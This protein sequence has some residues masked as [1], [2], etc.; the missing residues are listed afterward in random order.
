MHDVKQ[1]LIR[2]LDMVS[3]LVRQSEPSLWSGTS[4]Q[5]AMDS[6]TR[7]RGQLSE[8]GPVD[9]IKARLLFA[10]TGI[11]QEISIDNDWGHHFLELARDVD[12]L[13]AQLKEQA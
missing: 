10:P 6:L 4:H 2:K 1:H 11:L 5:S 3:E 12:R 8:A 13:L 7:L 9:I